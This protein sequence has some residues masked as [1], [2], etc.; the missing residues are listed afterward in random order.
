MRLVEN[1]SLTFHLVITNVEIRFSK[2]N[3][4]VS[5]GIQLALYYPAVGCKTGSILYRMQEEETGS[6]LQLALSRVKL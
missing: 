2:N 4:L 5:D 3:E 6:I 1:K